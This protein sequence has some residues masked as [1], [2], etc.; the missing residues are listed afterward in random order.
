MPIQAQA[1]HKPTNFHP[2]KT[3]SKW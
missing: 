3:T 1:T 2:R